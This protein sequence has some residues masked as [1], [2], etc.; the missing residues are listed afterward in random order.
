MTSNL[1]VA[2]GRV[3]F[4]FY[5]PKSKKFKVVEIGEKKYSRINV[6]PRIWFGFKGISKHES[7]ILILSNAT[8]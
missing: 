4:V 3:K 1:T 6:P 5:L 2:Y 8:H 7:I